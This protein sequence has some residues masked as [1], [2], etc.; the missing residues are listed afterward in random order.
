MKKFSVWAFLVMLLIGFLMTSGCANLREE[1]IKVSESDI[2]NVAAMEEAAQ[3]LL[4]TWPFYSGLIKAAFKDK[5]E[6]LPAITLQAIAQLD[7]IA[8]ETDLNRETLGY[9][10]G[11]RVL[12]AKGIIREALKQYA[13]DILELLPALL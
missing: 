5:L 12:M 1:I 8:K 11:L 9:S 3:N 10:L 2:K 7:E 13:P 6:E 4:L